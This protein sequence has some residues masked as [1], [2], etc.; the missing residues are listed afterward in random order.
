MT[1]ERI[2][3][4]TARMGVK[5]TAGEDDLQLVGGSPSDEQAAYDL[6]KG[7]GLDRFGREYRQLTATGAG[8]K[9][10]TGSTQAG[11]SGPSSPDAAGTDPYAAA[12]AYADSRYN[13]PAAAQR[14]EQR[15]LDLGDPGA[16]LKAP[17]DEDPYAAAGAYA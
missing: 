13:D 16:E 5:I 9:K 1:I 12:G 11:H 2:L 3:E 15:A 17:D 7:Y 14:Q 8:S 4:Q 6:I 10:E